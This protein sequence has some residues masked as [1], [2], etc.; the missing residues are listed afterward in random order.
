[1]KDKEAQTKNSVEPI[2]NCFNENLLHV[3]KSH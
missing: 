1:M 2:L 3:R